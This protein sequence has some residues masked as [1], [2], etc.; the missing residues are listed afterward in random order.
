MPAC[1]LW[2]HVF[3]FTICA[4][5]GPAHHMAHLL[6]VSVFLSGSSR[7]P[8]ICFRTWELLYLLAL[9]SVGFRVMGGH[10]QRQPWLLAERLLSYIFEFMLEFTV[11]LQMSIVLCENI[12]PSVPSVGMRCEEF[13]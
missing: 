10:G 7:F 11:S 2:V 5:G 6:S 3:P 8:C 12:C 13:H 9:V 1:L 4:K